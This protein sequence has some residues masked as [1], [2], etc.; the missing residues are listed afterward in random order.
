MQMSDA[1]IIAS[2][3]GAKNQKKQIRVLADLNSVN[4]DEMRLYLHQL[5]EPV[6]LPK[7]N[8]RKVRK[9]PAPAFDVSRALALHAE[10]LS[11]LDIAEQL[12]VKVTSFAAWRRGQGIPANIHRTQKSG[13]K[14]TRAQLRPAPAVPDTSTGAM[15]A[16]RLAEVFARIA[17]FHPDA[18]V[19]M[20][21]KGV[22]SVMLSSIFD[23]ASDA[24]V[25]VFLME[26]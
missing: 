23:N 22:A 3:R 26:A 13:K 7:E 20:D 12:G 15:T 5:G 25:Q 16:G 19:T 10:G 6:E 8:P 17:K 9:P 24:E 11:D 14:G 21:G 4:L 18:P 2:F 1:E